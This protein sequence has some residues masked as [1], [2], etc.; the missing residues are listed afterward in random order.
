MKLI[1][2]SASPRRA[3][4]LHSAGYE[5]TIV[6]AD[7]EE[8]PREGESAEDYTRRVALEK[9]A[10]VVSTAAGDHNL[11]LAADTEVVIDGRILGKPADRDDASRMLRLLSGRVHDVLTAVV[12]A[13]NWRPAEAAVVTKVWFSPLTVE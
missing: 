4:L 6:P 13:G 5:F 12:L 10:Q 11:V 7:I 8:V 1:L 9:A 2:A 3:E